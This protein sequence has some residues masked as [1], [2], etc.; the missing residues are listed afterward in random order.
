MLIGGSQLQ[1]IWLQDETAR[2]HLSLAASR[3]LC[4]P[5]RPDAS[6]DSQVSLTCIPLPSC[7][8][9]LVSLF[10]GCPSVPSLC[11][12]LFSLFSIS[13]LFLFSWP[14]CSTREPDPCWSQDFK[15]PLHRPC[16]PCRVAPIFILSA[17]C[18]SRCPSFSFS[19]L[20]LVF[21]Y[22]GHPGSH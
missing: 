10:L 9:R 20:S 22:F 4:I 14:P 15:W 13:S 2:I 6:T 21:T 11:P 19:F 3:A 5:F 18:P 8:L 7:I 17:L 1:A 16:H 12:S